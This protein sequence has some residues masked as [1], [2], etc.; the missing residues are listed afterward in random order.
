MLHLG[1]REEGKARTWPNR[2]QSTHM[3]L[4]MHARMHTHTCVRKGAHA[5]T[6]SH[7]HAHKQTHA[8]QLHSTPLTIRGGSLQSPTVVLPHTGAL[9]RTAVSLKVCALT[10]LAC[11]LGASPSTSLQALSHLRLLVGAR[12][13][14]GCDKGEQPLQLRCSCSCH[15]Q[16]DVT[17][18]R[19][20]FTIKSSIKSAI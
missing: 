19:V 15:H 13:Q 14:F 6:H 7:P 5:P 11:H 3:H 4:L 17:A 18:D 8:T 16:I 1:G 2:K 12:Q 10:S 9:S 20:L